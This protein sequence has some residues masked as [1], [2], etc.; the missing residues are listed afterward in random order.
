MQ[1]QDSDCVSQSIS[2]ER[3]YPVNQGYLAGDGE[4]VNSKKINN[5]KKSPLIKPAVPFFVLSDGKSSCL[6]AKQVL[7]H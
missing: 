2:L 3:I 1:H 7:H 6:H 4:G 5:W